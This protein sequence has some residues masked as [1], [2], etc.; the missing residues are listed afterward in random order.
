MCY[1]Q[2]DK[3]AA[4]LPYSGKFLREKSFVN[5]RIDGHSRKY[6]PRTFCVSIIA[7]CLYIEGKV[8][9]AKV[10]PQKFQF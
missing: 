10:F 8:T 7:L 6:T 3:F 9:H 2:R 5:L 1:L 4:P